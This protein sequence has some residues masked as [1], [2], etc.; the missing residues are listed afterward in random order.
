MTTDFSLA[1]IAAATGGANRNNGNGMAGDGNGTWWIM[2]LFLFMFCGW[3]NG[4]NGWGGNGNNGGATPYV[5][6][7]VTQSDLQRGFDNQAVISKLDGLSQG[8]CDSTYALNNS[9]TGGFSAAE[10][11][12]CNQQAALMQQ[13]C[14]MQMSAQN[15]CCE[16]QR[17]IE[18][19]FAD[20]NYNLAT[21]LCE[22]RQA[23]ASTARD[24]VDNQNS[25]TRAIM[26]FMTQKDISA[27]TAENQ[28]LKFQASQIAQNS[29]IDAVGNSMVARLQTPIPV[30]AYMVP[31]PNA[32]F[33]NTCTN[34]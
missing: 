34:C 25:N 13:L 31:N 15:C 3:G 18:R 5:T 2:I 1:D 21:Q 29:Y 11:S 22:T 17:Q 30:P 10:L 27:L 9:I 4:N 23:I 8:L 6:S 32:A 7:A 24:I 16:T 14:Q 26:D 33:C 19:G 12:R 28:M 20:T